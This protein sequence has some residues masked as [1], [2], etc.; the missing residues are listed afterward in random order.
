MF[1]IFKSF[2]LIL[3]CS[4]LL[5]NPKTITAQSSDLEPVVLIPGIMGSWSMDVLFKNKSVVDGWKFP[6][7]DQTWD[8]MIDALEKA[9]YEKDKTLF[10]F[11]IPRFL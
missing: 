11:F 9:G 7:T 3:V 8:N 10:I 5:V 6:P 4:F 1:R 2:Y